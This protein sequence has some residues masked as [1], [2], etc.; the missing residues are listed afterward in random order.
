MFP[1]GPERGQFVRLTAEQ[2][3]TVR[4]IYDSPDGLQDMAAAG[5]LAGYLVLLHICGPE[6]VRREFP[7]ALS[8]DI[9]T[10]WAAAGSHLRP[11]LRRVGACIVCPELGTRF[12]IAA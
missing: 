7:P 12:P 11:H 10:V 9:F 4:K 1:H 6:A 2:R 3:E 8:A 5:P